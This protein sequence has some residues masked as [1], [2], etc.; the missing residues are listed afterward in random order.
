[1]KQEDIKKV[2]DKLT[3][4]EEMEQR[5]SK[6][7]MDKQP[8]RFPYKR[9]ASIAAGLA[10][11]V[12]VGSLGVNYIDKKPDTSYKTET[13][14][15]KKPAP[16]DKTVATAEGITIPKIQLPK[17]TGV[18]MDMIG[19]IV[20]EGRIYTQSGT[21]ISSDI[22]EKFL[23]TKLGTTKGNIDEWSEQKDYAVEF[24]STVGTADVYSVKGYDKNF[25]IM[26]YETIDNTIY[27][28]FYDCFNGITVKNGEDIF[29]KLKIQGN[30]KSAKYEK[31][32]SWNNGKQILKELPEI[33]GLNDFANE[34][35]STAPYTRESLSYLWDEDGETNQKFIYITLNDGTEVQLRLFK[36]GYIY[37]DFSDVFFK[38]ENEA[39]D[40][41][42][43]ELQ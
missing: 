30:I 27:A 43:N 5:I 40:K 32:D 33:K 24:A 23:E 39:F 9:M 37:Y 35:K 10:L 41:L 3:P 12:F 7:M 17:E 31:F 19:L 25:R 14:S 1:M 6:T 18:A 20:Y 2:I 38:M 42:W 34:L 13:P 21:R 4:D 29:G 16:G 8:N 11:V 36:E 28:Q 22:G 15:G 26:T